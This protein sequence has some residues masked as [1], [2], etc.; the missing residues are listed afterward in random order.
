MFL[1][2]KAAPESKIQRALSVLFGRALDGM[3]IDHGRT[4]IAMPQHLLNN[5]D[6]LVGL[7][8]MAGKG[9]TEGVGR[10]AFTQPG[11]LDLGE[12]S[13]CKE[14]EDA[15]KSDRFPVT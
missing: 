8:E 4:D 14:D 7:E 5:V 11:L 6:V 10:S 13:V 9:V 12:R 3:G 15:D 1:Q 2:L